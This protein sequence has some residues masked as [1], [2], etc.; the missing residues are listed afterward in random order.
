MAEVTHDVYI[1]TE[2]EF[3]PLSRG[4]FKATPLRSLPD[5]L[6]VF[7]SLH[8][9]VFKSGTCLSYLGPCASLRP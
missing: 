1:V 4:R 8:N 3:K 7:F 2:L 9:P 5:W 6:N